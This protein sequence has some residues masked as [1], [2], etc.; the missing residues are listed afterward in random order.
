MTKSLN[1]P[2]RRM[3]AGPLYLISTLEHGAVPLFLAT[4]FWPPL[5]AE[6]VQA[7]QGTSA[8]VSL[9]RL[10]F[11]SAVSRKRSMPGGSGFIKS[12]FSKAPNT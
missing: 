10:Q 11:P 4:N 2:K 6:V 3:C 7:Y 12:S 5:S 1:Q 8:S 9:P